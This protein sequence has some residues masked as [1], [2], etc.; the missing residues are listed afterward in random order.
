[1]SIHISA[2]ETIATKGNK[3]AEIKKS[4]EFIYESQKAR[5]VNYLN[6]SKH[7]GDTL[8]FEDDDSSRFFE[9]IAAFAHPILIDTKDGVK[10]VADVRHFCKVDS[11]ANEVVIKNL[12]EYELAENRAIFNQ[13][14]ATQSPK[15][16]LTASVLPMMTFASWIT[17]NLAKR[18]S[19]GLLEQ[20]KLRVISAYYYYCLFSDDEEQSGLEKEKAIGLISRTLRTSYGD[21]EDVLATIYP[22]QNLEE[23]CDT[24]VE[25]L[26]S[27][28]VKGLKPAVVIAVVMSTWFG[29]NAREMLAVALEHPPTWMAI[30]LSAATNKI[31]RNT[32]IAKTA[33]RN[34]GRNAENLIRSLR[35]LIDD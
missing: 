3:I 11:Y 24:V 32:S 2:Y 28:R 6:V 14:F 30:C 19:L 27:P 17:D 21:T 10:T 34:S 12:P 15:L 33:E 4:L 16:L 29:A 31:F 5:N 35:S 20:F 18:L 25:R 22:I 9:D 13:L 23:F 8:L 7:N 1:M 26:D